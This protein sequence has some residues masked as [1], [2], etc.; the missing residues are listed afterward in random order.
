L[1][2][3]PQKIL[4]LHAGG[5]GDLLLALPALRIFRRAFPRYALDLMGRPERLSVVAFDLQAESIDSIDQA[6]MAYFYSDGETLPPRLSAFFS[7]FSCVLVFGKESGSILVKNFSRAGA[8]KVIT[9]PSFPPQESGI[10]VSEYLVEALGATGIEGRSSFSPLRLP[11]E[12]LTFARRF[13]AGLGLKEGERVLAIHPGSGSPGKNWDAKKFAAV[14]DWAS[15]R[16]QVLL[17]SGPAQHG[18]EEVRDSVKKARPLV[19]DNLPLIRLAAVLKASTVYLGNDSGITHLAASLGLPTVALFGPTNP[20]L[21][22]PKGPG[23]RIIYGKNVDTAGSPEALSASSRSSLE[24][25]QTDQVV[26]V[27]SPFLDHS[28]ASTPSEF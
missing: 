7:S 8:K 28:P 17:I 15:E 6:E 10:H 21:W 14:A 22:G 13:R 11:E 9:I 2:N 20:A 3:P 19:A 24:S 12:A 5:I 4:V 23:V 26:E 1:F 27:L 16:C 18:V 25:I